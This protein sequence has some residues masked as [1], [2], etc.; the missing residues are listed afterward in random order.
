MVSA[1]NYHSQWSVKPR[2]RQVPNKPL[3]VLAG[4]RPGL[5]LWISEDFGN[6]WSSYNIAAIHNVNIQPTKNEPNVTK[7]K[8]KFPEFS[9][10]IGINKSFQL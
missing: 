7:L 8:Y 3:L 4:G 1:S 6:T 5:F 2:L 9:N 10:V